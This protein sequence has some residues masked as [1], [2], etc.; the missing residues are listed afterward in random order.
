MK[1]AKLRARQTTTQ[2][3]ALWE[4]NI[5]LDNHAVVSLFAASK[6]Q[7]VVIDQARRWAVKW[8]AKDVVLEEE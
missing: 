5:F 3:D 2:T 7:Q 1:T 4:C 8:L 6:D